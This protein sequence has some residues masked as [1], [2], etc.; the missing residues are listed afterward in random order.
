MSTLRLLHAMPRCGSTLLS[1]HLASM[2]KIALLSEIHPSHLVSHPCDQAHHW[3]RL[4]TLSEAQA[5]K[6]EDPP[7]GELLT[8]IYARACHAELKLVVREWSYR[9]FRDWNEPN[10]LH[11]KWSSSLLRHCSSYFGQILRASLVREP[12]DQWL[13][14]QKFN[15]RTGGK[16]P[17]DLAS[18]TRSLRHFAEMAVTGPLVRFEDLTRYP[19]TTVRQV[20]A[21]LDLPYADVGD[22]W[23][24]CTKVTG[25]PATVR[26]Y[27]SVEVL[28]QR[29]VDPET[30]AQLR[31]CEDY[32]TTCR[33]LGYP[34]R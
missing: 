5:W 19:E 3:H 16:N 24:T 26:S 17:T 8:R 7:L 12:V 25:D 14:F 18:F 29:P 1:A 34:P 15:T 32:L 33:L 21:L 9:D 11:P 20:C 30:L 2:P 13:S 23:R 27:Q 6:L 31:D 22:A 10:P 28:P 4:I